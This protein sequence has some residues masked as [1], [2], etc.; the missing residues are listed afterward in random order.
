MQVALDFPLPEIQELVQHG[1]ARGDVEVLPDKCLKHA[2]MIRQ[3][4]ED[5]GG[6]QAII[7]QLPN[8]S[9]DSQLPLRAHVPGGSLPELGGIGRKTA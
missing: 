6:G 1:I 3:V 5:F 2:R 4:V 7:L 9:H 8:R